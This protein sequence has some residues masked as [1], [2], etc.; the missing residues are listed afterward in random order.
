MLFAQR[1]RMETF[2]NGQ[3]N[4]NITI[5][6]SQCD[7]FFGQWTSTIPLSLGKKESFYCNKNSTLKYIY[8]PIGL[9]NI[10]NQSDI[11]FKTP[12]FNE[13]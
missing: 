7:D 10:K 4:V 11:P 12:Q 6:N 9:S 3:K 2:L 13:P 5:L 1:S 8:N